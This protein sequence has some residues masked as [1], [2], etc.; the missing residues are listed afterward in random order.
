MEFQ[1]FLHENTNN[2]FTLN[3]IRTNVYSNY[4]KTVIEDIDSNYK[5]VMFISNRY[6]SDFTNPISAETNGIITEY[7]TLNNKFTI[8]MVPIFNF[9]SNKIKMI[10]IE[11][12]YNQ[13]LYN[14]HKVYD[15]TIINLYYYNNKWRISTNKGYDLTDLLITYKNTYYQIFLEISKQYINFNIDLLEKHKSYTFV[16]KYSDK[17]LFSEINSVNNYLIFMRS[18]DITELNNN[19]K[20]II[21]ENEQLGLPIQEKYE[22]ISY[23]ILH[24]NNKQ[25]NNNYLYYLKNKEKNY[26][27]KPNFGYI[28]TSKNINITQQY[29]NIFLESLLLKNI[30][31]LIY[32]YNYLPDSIKL[33]NTNS[34]DMITLNI[35]KCVLCSHYNNYKLYFP[36][37]GYKYDLI[38]KFIYN[39]LPSHIME[40]YNTLNNN[41]NNITSIVND[42]MIISDINNFYISQYNINKV[43][44][45][46]IILY[47]NIKNNYNIDIFVNDG[48]SILI[49]LI[50]RLEYI[51]IYYNC[52]I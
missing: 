36:K 7:D 19:N 45:A 35:L 31:K 12:F 17:H 16:M 51:H 43:N 22:N 13:Q 3:N 9:N 18:I 47:S 25:S 15:G 34:F 29:S 28:L 44:K 6:K 38:K 32:D 39:D 21:N 14:V 30:R 20:L 2:G 48:K 11:N 24:Y 1:K 37:Y 26:N 50:I 41:L 42:D 52:I 5:R 33:H 40:N 46:S 27:Y 23:N 49:D 4:I 8:L 10:N